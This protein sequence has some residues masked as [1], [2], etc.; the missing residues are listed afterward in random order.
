MTH[1]HSGFLRSDSFPRLVMGREGRISVFM[2]S[3][4]SFVRTLSLQNH[5]GEQHEWCFLLCTFQ[6]PTVSRCGFGGTEVLLV[7]RESGSAGPQFTN[8]A[9]GPFCGPRDPEGSA[10]LV[11]A[12]LEEESAIRSERFKRSTPEKGQFGKKGNRY[13]PRKQPEHKEVRVATVMCYRC[14]KRTYRA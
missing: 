5:R 13:V 4:I 1:F 7:G 9:R 3:G 12:A 10:Q 14:K 2:C 8:C 6:P 11:E